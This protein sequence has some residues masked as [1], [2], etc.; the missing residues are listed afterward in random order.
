[1]TGRADVARLF[2]V[3]DRELRTVLRTRAYAVLAVGFA[4][5]VIGL[6]WTSGATGYVPLVLD[7]LTPVEA[8]VPA[9]ALAFGYR[10]VLGDERRGELEV[11]RTYPLSR[12][13]YV[14][15]VYLGRAAALLVVVLAPLAAA[16]VFVPLVGGAQSSVIASHAGADSVLLYLRFLVLTAG[17]TLVVLSAA[18]A[19]S[20]TATDVRAAI[21]LG[22]AL[23]VALVV[24]FDFGVVAGL[25]AGVV[26]DADLQYVLA[27]SP[28]SAYRGLVLETVVSAVSTRATRAAAP[29]ANVLGLLLWLAA[30]LLVSVWTVWVD[31]RRP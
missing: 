24:G 6:A 29:L 13:G 5:L 2:A 22:V 16:A 19:V 21:A 1:M 9:L 15:G 4:V 17:F 31:V 30:T 18:L 14:L 3:S 12:W 10:S 20:T 7:L 25:A 26:G 27:L 23:L 8:L 28:N 11:V